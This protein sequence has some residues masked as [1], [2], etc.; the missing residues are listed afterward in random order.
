MDAS[1]PLREEYLIYPQIYG[2]AHRCLDDSIY[3][4]V[5]RDLRG[6]IVRF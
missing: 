2:Y 4:R 5:L 6:E 1:A 3:L